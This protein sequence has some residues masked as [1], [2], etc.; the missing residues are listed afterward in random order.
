MYK[1][2][3]IL[4]IVAMT[5]VMASCSSDTPKDFSGTWVG[6]NVRADITPSD[7]TVYLAADGGKALYWRGN[8][9]GVVD[10]AVVS[11]GDTVTMDNALFGSQDKTKTFNIVGEEI[12][13]QMSIMGVEKTIVLKKP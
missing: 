3:T 12:Q 11:E 7:I 10:D 9:P 1:K 8:W 13:F 4:L 5:F 6:D 2:L